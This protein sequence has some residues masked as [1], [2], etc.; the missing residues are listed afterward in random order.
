[1]TNWT[2]EQLE[3]IEALI[4]TGEQSVQ[5]EDKKVVYRGLG[6]LIGLRNRIKSALGAQVS[7]SGGLRI[8]YG[9][10]GKGL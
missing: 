1:M 3:H 6:E 8:S 7:R 9:S 4:A 5:Y 2:Q 10:F